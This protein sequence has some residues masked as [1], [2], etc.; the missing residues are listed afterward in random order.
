MPPPATH[1]HGTTLTPTSCGYDLHRKGQLVGH[2]HIRRDFHGRRWLADIFA[3]DGYTF[4]L[5]RRT[6][7][8]TLRETRAAVHEYAA[9]YD[10]Y[11]HVA[12]GDCHA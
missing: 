4:T 9:A 2:V 7:P 12:S 10:R 5:D 11:A 6:T 1:Q 8:A 3:Y